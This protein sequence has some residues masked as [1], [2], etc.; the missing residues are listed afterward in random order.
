M[1]P[2]RCNCIGPLP[3]VVNCPACSLRLHRYGPKC[4][5]EPIEDP[6]QR[7]GCGIGPWGLVRYIAE[8]MLIAEG[9]EG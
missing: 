4:V 3:E 6:G 9:L 7:V 1:L 5:Q 8:L 2:N